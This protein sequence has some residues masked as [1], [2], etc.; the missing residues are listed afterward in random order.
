[1]SCILPLA[2]ASLSSSVLMSGVRLLPEPSVDLRAASSGLT[3]DA[4][5]FHED[6]PLAPSPNVS[7]ITRN[8]P[9]VDS[10]KTSMSAAYVWRTVA[11]SSALVTIAGDQPGCRE[12]SVALLGEQQLE[13]ELGDVTSNDAGR[14]VSICTTD[15]L[16]AAGVYEQAICWSTV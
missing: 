1:M 15:T 9:L 8:P 7:L 10:A 5:A 14:E 12:R 16:G 2:H 3:D 13:R 11:M 6:R 4:G